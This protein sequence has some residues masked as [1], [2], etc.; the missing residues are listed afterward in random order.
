MIYVCVEFVDF[1]WLF[2]VCVVGVVFVCVFVGVVECDVDF[3]VV[4][5]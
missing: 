3:D 5:G 4:V 2:E 1:D